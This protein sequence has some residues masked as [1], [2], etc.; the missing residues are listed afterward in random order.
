M[1]ED[2]AHAL[3]SKF[4]WKHLGTIGLVGCYSFHG[5]KNAASGEGGAF[6]TND[7]KKVKFFYE[8]HCGNICFKLHR[9]NSVKFE[10]EEYIVYTNKLK[11]EDLLSIENVRANPS[12]FQDIFGHPG[13]FHQ[14]RFPF[15]R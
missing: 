3:G 12:M 5:T 6:V 8:T 11:L 13:R 7:P 9:S 1:I 14:V 4:K 2:A 15:L 10:N